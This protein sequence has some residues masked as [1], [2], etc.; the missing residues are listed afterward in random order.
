MDPTVYIVQKPD[1]KKNIVSA[2]DYG[3]FGFILDDRS[4]NITWNPD[5]VVHIISYSLRGFN[6]EDFL[7]PIGDPAAI[8]VC[9]AVAAEY[10]QGRVKFLKWDNRQY[11]YYPLEVKI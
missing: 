3:D 10:N 7:L 11:K 4:P 5:D 6:D 2:Q 1:P 8:G 9:T